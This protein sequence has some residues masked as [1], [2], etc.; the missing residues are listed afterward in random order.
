VNLV[1]DADEGRHLSL[2]RSLADQLRGQGYSCESKRPTPAVGQVQPIPIQDFSFMRNY[3]DSSIAQYLKRYTESGIHSEPTGSFSVSFVVN[4]ARFPSHVNGPPLH[5][6]PL[7]CEFSYAAL[8]SKELIPPTAGKGASSMNAQGDISSEIDNV[9]SSGRYSSLPPVQSIGSAGYGQP[10]LSIQNQ[11]TYQLTVLIAGPVERSV[12][13]SPGAS[14]DVALA[15]GSYKILGRV[16][17]SDVLP[18][19]G[20]QD[21]ATGGTYRESFYI[22]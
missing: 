15:P 21:Y 11:T 1:S 20:T 10:N 22:K 2:A 9:V 6:P 17:A 4:V 14:V 13:V 19:Y 12:M 7:E 8:R 5:D 16:N 3:Y 18:F